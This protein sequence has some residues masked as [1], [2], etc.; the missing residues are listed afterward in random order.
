MDTLTHALSGAVVARATAP[1]TPGPN[2][3]SVRARV[4]AGAAAAAFPDIDHVLGYISPV[5][6]LEY[7]RG[8][9]HSILLLPLWALMLAWTCSRIARDP[10]GTGPW[11]GV[12]ALGLAV[13]IAGDLI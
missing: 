7:H 6:Y 5:V 11:F 9:T 8:L 12:C 2:E 3:L 4:L 10:R 1:R 13:H